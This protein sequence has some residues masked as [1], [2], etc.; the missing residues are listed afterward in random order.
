VDVVYA[1]AGM[2]IVQNDIGFAL[3]VLVGFFG[4]LRTG[5]MLGL[6]VRDFTFSQN[7]DRVHIDLGR[8]KSGARKGT[9]EATVID[10][11]DVVLFVRAVT[12]DWEPFRLLYCD[13]PQKFRVAFAD[14]IRTLDLG[15]RDIRPYSLRRGGVAHLFTMTSSMQ[16]TQERGRWSNSSVARIYIQDA[17]RALDEISW[18]RAQ[19]R[20]IASFSSV[21]R[22]LIGRN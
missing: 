6:S 16:L 20:R 15:G 10:E 5:E 19:Q 4:I 21:Y 18:T 3:L 17:R 8:T 22:G 14:R 13:S 7:L 9:V 11:P 1:L 2:A 12:S